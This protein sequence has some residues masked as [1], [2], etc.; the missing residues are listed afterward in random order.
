MQ[1]SS[2]WVRVWLLSASPSRFKVSWGQGLHLFPELH[3]VSGVYWALVH[4]SMLSCFH[5]VQIWAI[6]WTVACY[7]PLSMGFFRQ[8]YWSGWPC[9]LSWDLPNPGIE[10]TSLMFPALAGG[11]FTTS[12]TG[13]APVS[14]CLV[15]IYSMNDWMGEY[16]K[17]ERLE[18]KRE[19]E[20]IRKM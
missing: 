9:P 15:K 18:G 7:T 20:R 8:E 11:Y 6:L 19:H 4:V 16:L 14:T 12:A 1:I 13:E 17:V 5:C 10:P 3:R 2:A